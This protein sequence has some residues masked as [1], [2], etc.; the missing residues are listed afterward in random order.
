VVWPEGFTVTNSRMDLHPGGSYHY[1][2]TG[3]DGTP[4]WGKFV[5]REIVPAK[6][7]V[8]LSSFSD[9]SAGT[10][11]HLMAPDWPLE[12]LSSF[13]FEE[14]PGEKT[15]ITIRASP[16]NASEK[17]RSTFDAGRDRMRIGWSGT[18]DQL[19]PYLQEA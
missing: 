1:G 7:M 17:E 13:N 18:F 19:A 3:S 12:M 2:L 16:H 9:P 10:T 14:Q 6:Q 5:F 8:V 4:M 15:E 11:R